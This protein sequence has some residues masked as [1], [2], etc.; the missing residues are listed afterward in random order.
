MSA[1]AKSAREAMKAKARRLA[2]E[3][4]GKVDASS[5]RIPDDMHAKAKTGMRPVSKRAY[6]RGGAV[7]GEKSEARAD[8]A[9]RKS[10][11]SIATELINRN[12][13]D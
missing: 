6:K 8:R 3:P 12:Q 7:A 2:S 1:Q 5:Y 11:G 4:A 9:P 10:G 13:V